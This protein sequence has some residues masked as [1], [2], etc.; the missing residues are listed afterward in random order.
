MKSNWD[1]E[2]IIN[3]RC[4]VS[5]STFCTDN[6][7]PSLE[8]QEVPLCVSKLFLLLH[9]SYAKLQFYM[10]RPSCR[11][12][13]NSFFF[14][15]GQKKDL[16]HPSAIV[17]LLFQKMTRFVGIA[18]IQSFLLYNGDQRAEEVVMC[19]KFLCLKRWL[20]F[21]KRFKIWLSTV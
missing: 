21:L 10:E 7:P 11:H 9:S 12:N 14:R 13:K 5:T 6:N 4:L 17:E 18:E 15:R 19:I 3:T 8:R 16:I 1:F 20:C 2:R